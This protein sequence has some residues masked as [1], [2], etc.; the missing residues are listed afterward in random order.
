MC[1]RLAFG[2]AIKSFVKSPIIN[3]YTTNRYSKHQESLQILVT[4]QAH[5]PLVYQGKCSAA[6]WLRNFLWSLWLFSWHF[7]I[8]CA[9][10]LLSLI[11]I[12]TFINFM[13]NRS[14]KILSFMQVAACKCAHYTALLT[15]WEVS[16]GIH[17][18]IY[19][20]FVFA[21]VKELCAIAFT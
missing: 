21:C 17:I 11:A 16:E 14:A 10:F 13:T 20:K 2:T 5:K 9:Y 7:A 6:D 8:F 3:L 18:I 15:T 19:V 12:I 4:S 1:S